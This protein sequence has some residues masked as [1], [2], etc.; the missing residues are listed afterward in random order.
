MIGREGAIYHFTQP[1]TNLLR[2]GLELRHVEERLGMHRDLIIRYSHVAH[3]ND[4][5]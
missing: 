3:E 4:A 5:V 2:N 1:H